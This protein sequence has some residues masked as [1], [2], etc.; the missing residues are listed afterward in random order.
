MI[1]PLKNLSNFM[2]N[3]NFLLINSKTELIL[4]WS[5][6]CVLTEQ[7][8]REVKAE[9]PAQGGNQLV[10]AVRAINR[11]GSLKFNIPDCKLYVPVV[12]LQE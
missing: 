4:K 9:I 8:T 2:F 10:S 3:L 1:V 12:T 6:H 7:V 5:Q 11:P